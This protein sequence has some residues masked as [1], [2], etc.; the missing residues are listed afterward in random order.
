[1]IPATKNLASRLT[2]EITGVNDN[3][4]FGFT[5]RLLFL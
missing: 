1:M 4:G 5:F 3:K 2:G